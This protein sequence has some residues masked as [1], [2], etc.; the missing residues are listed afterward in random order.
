MYGLGDVGQILKI[1]D[2]SFCKLKCFR[3]QQAVLIDVIKPSVIPLPF[4]TKSSLCILMPLDIMFD[5]KREIY[6]ANLYKLCLRSCVFI[7]SI[8]RND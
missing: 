4:I 3:S 5:E 8:S 7:V 1:S 2:G 6:G